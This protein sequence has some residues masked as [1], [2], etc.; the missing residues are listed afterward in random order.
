MS[1]NEQQFSYTVEK[2]L[3]EHDPRVLEDIKSSRDKLGEFTVGFFM[4]AVYG[5]EYARAIRKEVG[6]L[7]EKKLKDVSMDVVKQADGSI[8]TKVAGVN[9]T[10][11]SAEKKKELNEALT[12]HQDGEMSRS[13]A[14][15]YRRAQQAAIGQEEPEPVEQEDDM[16]SALKALASMSPTERD[17]LLKLAK[18]MGRK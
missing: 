3:G 9:T 8:R 13:A 15:S 7:Y 5:E 11:D 10:P 18:A 1:K 4:E 17:A 16:V 6:V 2:S 14:E 12:R